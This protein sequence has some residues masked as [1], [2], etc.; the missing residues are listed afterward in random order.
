MYN[1]ALVK[2]VKVQWFFLLINLVLWIIFK[3]NI[4][5]YSY[6]IYFI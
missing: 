1:V 2:M 3:E 5:W 4:S 6:G